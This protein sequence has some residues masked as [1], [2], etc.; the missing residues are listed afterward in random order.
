MRSR[1]HHLLPIT[2]LA[3]VVAAFAAGC[4]SSGDASPA[5]TDSTAPGPTN[6]SLALDWYPNPD[7]VGIYAGIDHGFFAKAGL[8]VTP[9]TPADVSDPI[10]F[11]GANRADLGVSY[12][13]EVFFAAQKEIPVVAVAALVPT[14]L[15][16]IIARTDRGIHTVSDLRGTTIGVD[17]SASTTAYVQ[18]VLKTAG[19]P[20][21]SVHLVTVGFNLLPALLSGRVDAIAGGFQNIEGIEARAHGLATTVFPVDRYGVPRYD[22]LV[23]VANRAR[24]HTDPTYRKTVR[25]FVTALTAA[26]AW[27][28][29]HPQAAIAIMRAHSSRDYLGQIEKSVPATLRL[30]RTSGL[31]RQAWERFGNWMWS[32]GLLS[33]QPD[34]ARLVTRP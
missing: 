14:A 1:F 13:P 34:G 22:E 10:K 25:K 9:L 11:V 5:T 32:Q 23:I 7:H 16:S 30:L 31:N 2:L 12:E 20:A 21:D 27:A 26:T 33:G 6:V 18:T 28:R 4:G 15:N 24:L 29:A 17:G 8:N 3:L 19:V